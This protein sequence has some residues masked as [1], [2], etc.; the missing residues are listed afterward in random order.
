MSKP[1]KDLIE[2]NPQQKH[3][4]NKSIRIKHDLNEFL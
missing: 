1:K 2:E 3:P 4:K